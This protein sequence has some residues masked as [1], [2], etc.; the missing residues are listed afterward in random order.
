M[1]NGEY[2]SYEDILD[3]GRYL[4]GMLPA[5]AEAS[6]EVIVPAGPG[7][8]R[9]KLELSVTEELLRRAVGMKKTFDPGLAEASNA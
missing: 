7:R 4:E 5:D 1:A 6:V 3:A 8:I 2:W 9:M